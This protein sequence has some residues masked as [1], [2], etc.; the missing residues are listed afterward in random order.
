MLPINFSWLNEDLAGSGHPGHRP[1][2]L[3]KTLEAL[4][5]E[6]VG[7]VVSLAPLDGQVVAEAGLEHIPLFVPDM[8]TPEMEE[9]AAAVERALGYLKEGK[10]LLAHC[11]AGYGRT[12]LFLACVLVSQGMDA[13]TAIGFVRT[14]RPGS[15]ETRGQEELILKWGGQPSGGQ[16]TQS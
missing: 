16:Q 10:R 13:R 5:E 14:G 6:G 2:D 11:G 7:V 4:K 12:G 15:I 3:Q 9:L 1:E 8:G